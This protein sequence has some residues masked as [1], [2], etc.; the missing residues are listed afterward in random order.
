[1]D[2]PALIGRVCGL[3]ADVTIFVG[4]ASGILRSIAVDEMGRAVDRAY[5]QLGAPVGFIVAPVFAVMIGMTVAARTGAS[6][7]T[8]SRGPLLP[9]AA[10]QPLTSPIYKSAGS[11]RSGPRRRWTADRRCRARG[12]QEVQR[13]GGHVGGDGSCI[14]RKPVMTAAVSSNHAAADDGSWRAAN[15]AVVRVAHSGV[16]CPDT[17]A[18]PSLRSLTVEVRPAGSAARAAARWTTATLAGRCS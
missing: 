17:P 7:M 1:M 5:W 2:I 6:Q 14:R 3:R 16:A 13:V 8:R 4:G 12:P 18:D 15:P 11:R 10:E 9:K